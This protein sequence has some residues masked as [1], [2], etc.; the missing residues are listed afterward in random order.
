RQLSRNKP[1]ILIWRGEMSPV[2]G[3]F[4][5]GE[6]IEAAGARLREVGATNKT[7]LNDYAEA[8]GPNAALIL[9]VHRSNF[10]MSGFVESPLSAEICALAHRKRVP[11]VEDLG[12]GAIVATDQFGT[13][14]HEPMPAE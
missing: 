4:R 11:F 9:K 10:F 2:V 12:S 3:G 6:T 14:D 13:G 7:T 1:L 8:I 5:M